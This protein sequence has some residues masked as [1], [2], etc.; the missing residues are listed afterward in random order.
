MQED[1]KPGATDPAS[2]SHAVSRVTLPQV[3]LA[4]L[5]DAVHFDKELVHFE[6]CE[7]G[8]GNRGTAGI[9]AQHVGGATPAV[10]ART[11]STTAAP[12]I[13]GVTCGPICW[14]DKGRRTVRRDAKRAAARRPVM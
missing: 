9:A 1:S 8:A 11:S 7:G 6:Q 3:L 5:H 13:S 2:G 14:S 4:G 12:A 10:S